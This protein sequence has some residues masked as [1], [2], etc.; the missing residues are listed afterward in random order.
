MNFYGRASMYFVC[1]Y[2]FLDDREL[3]GYKTNTGK[4]LYQKLQ[5]FMQLK[6]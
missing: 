6:F 2:E 3:E 1:D 5:L 4:F